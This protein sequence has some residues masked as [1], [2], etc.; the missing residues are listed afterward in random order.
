MLL[1]GEVEEALDFLVHPSFSQI[2]YLE[3]FV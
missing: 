3:E 1:H 2:I